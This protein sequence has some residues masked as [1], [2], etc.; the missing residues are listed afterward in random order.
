M[1]GPPLFPGKPQIRSWSASRQPPLG[2]TLK[3]LFVDPGEEQR[4]GKD[5]FAEVAKVQ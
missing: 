1:D 5:G 3:P 2:W 4:L